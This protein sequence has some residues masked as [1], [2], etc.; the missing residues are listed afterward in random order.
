MDP[1][2]PQLLETAK[3]DLMQLDGVEAVGESMADGHPCIKV[4]FS[5]EDALH[6]AI[7]AR[8]NGIPILLVVSGKILKQI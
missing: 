3:A 8:C 2:D 7:I 6:R 5:N 4:Y 1:L